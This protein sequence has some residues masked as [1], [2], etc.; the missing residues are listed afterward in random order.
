MKNKN[1]GYVVLG[2]LFVLLNVVV[3]AIPTDKTGTF[4]VAYGFTVA[5]FT[6]Q[7]GIWQVAFGK[8]NTAKSRFLGIPA[9]YI[10]A[11]YLLF[12][13]VV[14]IVF[15]A[16]PILPAWSAVVICS[17]IMGISAIC[18]VAGKAGSGEIARV[19]AKVQKKVFFIRDLQVDVE[20]LA[21]A[22]TDADTRAALQQLAEKIRYSDSMSNDGLAEIER[23]ITGKVAELKTVANKMAVIQELHLLLVERNK[24][25]KILKIERE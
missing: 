15:M 19:E 7:P 2:I 1:L 17:A 10:G 21:V 8:G 6:I 18:L 14:L 12:Q 3:F 9:V 23:A 16:A 24:K 20:L 5:A 11:V 22:E 13:I 4:W 25:A